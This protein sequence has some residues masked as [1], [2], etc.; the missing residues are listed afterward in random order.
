MRAQTD[1]AV[2]G[3]IELDAEKAAASHA[4][5]SDNQTCVVTANHKIKIDEGELSS[6]QLYRCS[7][8]HPHG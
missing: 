7:G 8:L 3:E 2:A 1:A 5:Q 6:A 4:L